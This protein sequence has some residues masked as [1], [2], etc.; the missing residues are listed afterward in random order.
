M[1]DNFKKAFF[2]DCRNIVNNWSDICEK[3]NNKYIVTQEKVPNVGITYNN[4]LLEIYNKLKNNA[5]KKDVNFTTLLIPIIRYLHEILTLSKLCLYGYVEVVS[6]IAESKKQDIV[7][8]INEVEDI[9]KKCNELNNEIYSFN[10]DKHMSLVLEQY[11]NNYSSSQY[12]NYSIYN[13]MCG[14]LV[15]IYNNQLNTVNFNYS[16]PVND[17]SEVRVNANNSDGFEV[18]DLE[19]L[20]SNTLKLIF[21]NHWNLP[22]VEALIEYRV[23]IKLNKAYL[24]YDLHDV[25]SYNKTVDEICNMDIKKEIVDGFLDDIMSHEYIYDEERLNELERELNVLGL[26][27][28]FIKIKNGCGDIK[29]KSLTK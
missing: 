6:Q 22:M 4:K 5:K 28:S 10:I 27:D 26:D 21:D 2:S 14:L 24:F 9:I 7:P 16:L 11:V 13:Q 18:G 20:V 29:T 12:S 15:N 25:N 3:I 17:N 1:D 8:F 19:A 23:R